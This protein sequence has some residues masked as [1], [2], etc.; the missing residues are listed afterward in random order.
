[1]IRQLARFVDG[2]GSPGKLDYSAGQGTKMSHS[3]Q[4]SSIYIYF[5]QFVNTSTDSNIYNEITKYYLQDIK[6]NVSNVIIG[7]IIK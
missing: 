5:R 3:H 1:M 7:S 4:L 6:N 2:T